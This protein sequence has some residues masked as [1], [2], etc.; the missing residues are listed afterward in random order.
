MISYLKGF[1]SHKSDKYIILDVYRV[2]Y[3]I[4]M[5]KKSLNNIL[6]N[7]IVV[8]YNEDGPIE[9]LKKVYIEEIIK[10][11]EYTLYGFVDIEERDMFKLLMK[12]N[13]IGPNT[14][15]TI[16][17]NIDYNELRLAIYNNDIEKI[18]G[19]KGIGEN[20][21]QKI[22]MTLKSKIKLSDE[23][24]SKVS[25][26]SDNKFETDCINALLKLGYNIT[27]AKKKIQVVLKENPLCNSIEEIVKLSFK[28]II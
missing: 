5:T 2:G 19:V 20:S 6:D 27:E 28:K 13:G 23:E 24:K 22:I 11:N 4:N 7:D 16:L 17:S 26:K 21:A 10:E 1:I 15:I 18:K 25:I 9:K 14:T 8:V 12:V 3:K